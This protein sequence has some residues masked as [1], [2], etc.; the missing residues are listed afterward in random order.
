[1]KRYKGTYK[2]KDGK[3][4]NINAKVNEKSLKRYAYQYTLTATMKGK[5]ATS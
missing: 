2:T 3:T 1:M 5:M 4:I